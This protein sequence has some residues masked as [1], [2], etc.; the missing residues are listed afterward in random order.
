MNDRLK[1]R[2]WSTHA[3]RYFDETNDA[4]LENVFECMKQQI[5]YDCQ[6]PVFRKIYDRIAYNHIADGMVFEQCTGLKDKNGKLIYEGD[7]VR[8]INQDTKDRPDLQIGHIWVDELNCRWIKFAKEELSWNDFCSLIDYDATLE[9]EVI[10]N[11][12]KNA[13]MLGVK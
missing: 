10:G 2:M 6:N 11:E 7:Y 12:H 3:G 8:A 9:I 13:D 1:W 5:C 4:M